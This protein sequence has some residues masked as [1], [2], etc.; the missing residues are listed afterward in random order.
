[1][2]FAVLRAVLQGYFRT[3]VSG[4]ENVPPPGRAT[5]LVT[6]HSS[7]LDILAVGHALNRPGRFLAK[8]EATRAPIMGPY[9]LAVGAI[10]T[11][12]D[13]SDTAA[14]R[15]TLQILAAGGLVGLAP[16]GTRSADGSVGRYES[17]FVWLAARTSA[18]IVPAAI[19]GARQLM[20]KG[21]L[22]PRRGR[23]WVRFGQPVD[24]EAALRQLGQ[25]GDAD[26]PRRERLQAV[27]DE[28]RSR[29][30]AMLAD[31]EAEAGAA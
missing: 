7:T 12:R 26:L 19:F 21:A 31:L 4:K 8:A 22:I 3:T 9:M 25:P 30:V 10:P 16:E 15:T 5:I 17:G 1:M 2:T 14:L 18:V 13:G 6:N 24:A 27:A 23:I 11:K 29:T 20:P 28:V